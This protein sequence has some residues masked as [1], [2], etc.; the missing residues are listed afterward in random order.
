MQSNPTYDS[1]KILQD[2]KPAICWMNVCTRIH[3]L[4]YCLGTSLLSRQQFPPSTVS[5]CVSS[6]SYP[7]TRCK[8]YFL[9][10]GDPDITNYYFLVKKT[11]LKL[12]GKM[13]LCLYKCLNSEVRWTKEWIWCFNFCNHEWD[14]VH[15]ITHRTFAWEHSTTKLYTLHSRT[16]QKQQW[17]QIW[18][19]PRQTCF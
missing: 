14:S 12:K 18:K 3:H 2:S 4:V 5:T 8:H 13:K 7:N 6:H 15:S 1:N 17:Y 11:R 16:D 19:Y 9:W 10:A